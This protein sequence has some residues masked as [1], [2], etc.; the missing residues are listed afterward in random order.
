[1]KVT[2]SVYSQA[3]SLENIK[4]ILNDSDNNYPKKDGVPSRN[5][6]TYNNGY[7]VGITV[8][9]IDIRESKELSSKHTRP[10]LAKIYRAYIS[11]LIAVMRGN[12]RISEIF[13]EGDGLW[14]VYDTLNNEQV[15][16]VLSTAARISSL[17]KMLNK[18]LVAKKYS[19]LKVG[20]GIED[21]ETLYMQAGYKNSGIKE[22]VWIGKAVGESAKLCN[23]GNRT[24]NDKSMMISERVYSMLS[25]YQQELF[26]F[27][28]NRQ[29]YHG[30][31]VNTDMEKYTERV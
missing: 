3:K 6:L 11:E 17:I 14:A 23:Y 9:F 7:Y 8:L 30:D 25:K 15:Q 1:M 2:H 13:I 12:I 21:G 26:E 24:F 4:E 27:N 10:V 28:Y 16:S 18:K 5:S 20:L 22:V 19:P 31:V 29:C